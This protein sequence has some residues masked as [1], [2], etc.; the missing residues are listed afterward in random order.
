[1]CIRDRIAGIGCE[2]GHMFP[3]FFGLRGG[4]GILSGGVAPFNQIQLSG[5]L[6]KA[7]S[8]RRTPLGREICDLIRCV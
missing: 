7:P 8:L 6:C 2:L 1:M 4:K 5:V 3:V